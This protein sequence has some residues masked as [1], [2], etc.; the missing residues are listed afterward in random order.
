MN[1][2]FARD[3]FL[4]SFNAHDLWLARYNVGHPN[5]VDPQ[6]SN[7]ENPGTSWANPYGIWNDPIGAAPSHDSWSFWQYS[8]AGVGSTTARAARSSTWICSTGRWRKLQSEFVMPEPGALTL[9]AGVALL[10]LGRRRRSRSAARGQRGCRRVAGHDR[11]PSPTLQPPARAYP[12]I[13]GRDD[14]KRVAQAH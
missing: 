14:V 8:N 7:P 3:N 6:T 9:A 2:T 4:T 11:A 1:S 13:H 5:S 12:R 10:A